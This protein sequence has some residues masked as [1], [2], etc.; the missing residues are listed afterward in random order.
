[1][2]T[3]VI[4][5]PERYWRYFGAYAIGLFGGFILGA[6]VVVVLRAILGPH[7]WPWPV[8]VAL[9][10]FMAGFLLSGLYGLKHNY[11]VAKGV[12]RVVVGPGARWRNYIQ[13]LVYILGIA[14]FAWF[15]QASVA[16]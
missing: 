13:F 4:K 1:M 7:Y 3:R 15:I 2:E 9:P 5:D 8:L 16:A 6:V 10:L 14:V 11:A 12:N